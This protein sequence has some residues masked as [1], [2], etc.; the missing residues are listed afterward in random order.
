V[1]PLFG[2][3]EQKQAEIAAAKAEADRLAALTPA[4]LAV[5]VMPAFGPGGPKASQSYG[6]NVLQ[7]G[8]ALMEDTP[9]GSSELKELIEP[10]R[11]ALQVLE[12]AELIARNS[13]REGTW[14]K[15]TRLGETALAEG[16][17]QTY[18]DQRT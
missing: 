4:Q 12:H 14:F 18:V 8:I 3:R 1:S 15:A 6:I 17:V 16:S 9:R 10:I 13:G 7:V 2:N 5:E 11:E